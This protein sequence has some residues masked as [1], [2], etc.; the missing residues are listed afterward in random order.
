MSYG[1]S[2][3]D[4]VKTKR[5]R[6]H[7]VMLPTANMFPK[8]TA[9]TR[10]RLNKHNNAESLDAL[11]TDALYKI[12]LSNNT[13]S[14]IRE[15]IDRDS[16]VKDRE[17][18]LKRAKRRLFDINYINNGRITGRL[19]ASKI[20]EPDHLGNKP[21][22]Q[23]LATGKSKYTE[24]NEVLYSRSGN[25]LITSLDNP[26]VPS[27]S[28]GHPEEFFYDL[29]TSCCHIESKEVHSGNM[30]SSCPVVSPGKHNFHQ[31]VIDLDIPA[32]LIPSFQNGHS[33]LYLDVKL[34]W[35]DYLKLLKVMAEVGIIEKEYYEVSKSKGY[36]AVRSPCDSVVY[37][38]E[39]G[40]E[41]ASIFTSGDNAH[42]KH[43]NKS[44]IDYLQ[45]Q[46][47]FLEVEN[48]KLRERLDELTNVTRR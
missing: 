22:S 46:I 10:I 24:Q 11:L 12:N 38:F 13:T 44:D 48:E 23:Y 3:Q 29:V 39:E 17:I 32:K 45:E 25:P 33:H 14:N 37:P 18:A 21:D 47:D 43:H 9:S 30:V 19:H 6:P 4:T 28:F 36:T 34:T 27:F 26:L 16:N 8:A 41:S 15:Y 42:N 7:T 1:N 35:G 31:P 20:L 40:Y 5:P 2:T